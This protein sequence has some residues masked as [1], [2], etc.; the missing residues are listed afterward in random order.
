MSTA[1]HPAARKLPEN[2]WAA[3]LGMIIRA[4]M[5]SRP[6]TR[7]ATTTVTAVSTARMMLSA[8]TGRPEARAYSS[9]PATAKSRSRRTRVA[10]MMTED[11]TAKITTSSREV[12]VM[13]PK[14]KAV[15]LPVCP[16]SARLMMT[17]PAAMPP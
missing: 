1:H 8:S 4:L 12:V 16:P 15:R 14:R 9:S 2:C 11:S 5:S 17:T 3:A 6:M 7:I 13:A 10:R